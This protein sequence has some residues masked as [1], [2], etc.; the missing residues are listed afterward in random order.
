MRLYSVWQTENPIHWAGS[1]VF[2]SH[3]SNHFRN[4]ICSEIHYKRSYF[5]NF[6]CFCFVFFFQGLT[7]GAGLIIAIL[8]FGLVFFINKKADKLFTPS[9]PLDEDIDS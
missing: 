1:L 9:S 8:S 3:V 4:K 6:F 5:L 7:L 2:N